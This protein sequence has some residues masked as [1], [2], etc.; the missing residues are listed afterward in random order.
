[1]LD[2]GSYD[3]NS[4]ERKI[5]NM[6]CEE[7]RSV[8]RD[9][10]EGTDERLKQERDKS[11]YRNK[12]KR[13]TSIKTLMGTVEYHRTVYEVTN[14]EQGKMY[15]FL[16]DD[17][18]CRKTVGLYSEALAESIVDSCCEMPYRAAANAVSEMTGH[19]VSHTGA[20]KV[21]QAVGERIDGQEREASKE[22]AEYRG[23]GRHESK[24]LFE[25]QDGVW[26]K[27]QGSDRKKYG[28]AKEMK[29][30]ITYS[31]AKKT[32]KHRYELQ[33]K[34][35]CA[36]FEEAGQFYA[37]KEGVIASYYAVD[38]IEMRILNGDGA[39]WIQRSRTDESIH[40]QLDT[41]HRNR[42]IIQAV[43]HPKA[44][45][46]IFKLL[47]DKKIPQML[48]YIEILA[49]SVTDEDDRQELKN[50]YQY[51]HN[52]ESGLIG[53]HRRGLDLP[54]APEGL[55]YRRCGAMESNVFSLIGFRMK[56]RRASWSVAGGNNL[57]R[58]LC[59]KK[60]KRL[61]ESLRNVIGTAL[62]PRYM[63]EITK[64]LSASQV[65]DRTG[66]GY[67]GYH[68]FMPPSAKSRHDAWI[69]GLMSQKSFST[70]TLQ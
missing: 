65:S 5:Y 3:F 38:E 59:L 35:A 42:A 28:K 34:V 66:K 43:K 69:K 24:V 36:S 23:R 40:Y 67:D 37:R 62:P 16:L 26:L 61:G 10:L 41:F 39:K 30:A 52:N 19:H 12:G 47:Y 64:I 4:L 54:E 14:V 31:G 25:E 53:Y 51:L 46:D 15:I 6:V 70:M 32:G 57:A 22:A 29:L 2:D 68:H 9:M 63:E 44:R 48:E 13:K 45:K 1:M 7:G 60:T 58:L 18:L 11:I 55:L 56:R 20:W 17:I 8:F 21:V 50:L 49:N 27:L 33:D